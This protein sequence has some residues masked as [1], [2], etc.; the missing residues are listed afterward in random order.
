[1][2]GMYP[3]YFGD[4][5]VGKVQVSREGL[6]Y[7]FS[8]RCILSGNVVCRLRVDCG[9]KR[10]S[11]GVVVPMGEGFGLDTR[12][13]VKRIGEGTPRFSLG[14]KTESRGEFIPLSPEEPFAYL[15]RLKESFLEIR[16]GQAGVVLKASAPDGG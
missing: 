11:L 12:V 2:E 10:E 14:A 13:P 7:R 9:G 16:N 5:E 8:C 4:G 3:V 1:M 15:E 6:Y